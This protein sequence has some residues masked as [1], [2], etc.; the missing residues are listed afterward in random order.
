MISNFISN[1]SANNTLH[2]ITVYKLQQQKLEL[3]LNAIHM[4]DIENFQ[5]K[6][7]IFFSVKNTAI[8]GH[9]APNA[10]YISRATHKLLS[11]KPWEGET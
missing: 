8:S 10:R 9:S 6:N 7:K 1:S 4:P 2:I 5:F 3:I 11:D